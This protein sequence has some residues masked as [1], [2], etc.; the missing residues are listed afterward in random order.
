MMYL[1]DYSNKGWEGTV[2]VLIDNIHIGHYTL[3]EYEYE[4]E[5]KINGI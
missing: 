4:K 5:V 2:E 1:Y 3:Y